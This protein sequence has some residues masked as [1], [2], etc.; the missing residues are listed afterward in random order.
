MND[1]DQKRPHPAVGSKPAESAV[2][3][4]DRRPLGTV[5]VSSGSVTMGV[6]VD[7]VAVTVRVR[8]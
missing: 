8:V 4:S 7:E 5:G 6:I 1:T 3:P 2:E